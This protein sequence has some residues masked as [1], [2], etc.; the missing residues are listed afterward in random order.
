VKIGFTIFVFFEAFLSGCIPT[1]SKTCR[2]SPKILGIANSFAAGVFLAIA[3]VHILPEEAGNW[4]ELHPDADNLFPLPYFLMFC[5]Y[6]MIL[7]LDKVLFDTHALF[8]TNESNVL[9]DPVDKK[10]AA[11]IK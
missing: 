11:S 10:L 5:G 4:A 7:I 8:E 3:F 1:W 2:E 9:I 6:T